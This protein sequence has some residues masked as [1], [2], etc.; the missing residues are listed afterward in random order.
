MYFLKGQQ[1]VCINFI[2]FLLHIDFWLTRTN[3]AKLKDLQL[4]IQ[5][6]INRE[7]HLKKCEEDPFPQ[8]GLKRN[9]VD[10]P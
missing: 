5:A 9:V 6:S 10:I 1:K 2:L 7:F 4:I 3:S 8:V